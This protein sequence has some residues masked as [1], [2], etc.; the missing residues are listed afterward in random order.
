[1]PTIANP[2][3]WIGFLLFV[4]AMLALDLGVFHRKAHSVGFREAA[5]WSG[6]W[7]SLSMLFGAGLTWFSGAQAGEEFFTG[8]LIEKS[9][10][11]DNIFVF[12]L[13]FST[14]AIPAPSQHRVLFWGIL[15]ALILRA[16]MIFAGVALLTHFHWLIY[17]F[18]AFLLLT[19]VRLLRSWH[20]GIENS[21]EGTLQ[22]IRRFVPSTS[23]LHGERFFIREKGKRLATPLFVALVLVEVTDIIFAVDSIPAI[24]AV[25]TDPFIVFT[26][27]ILALMGLRS[28][29]FL[30]A[31]LVHKF[32]YL[33]P[34]LA[35]VLLFV[36][37]KMV[38][39]DWLPIPSVVSLIVIA[40][41]LA[42]G[43]IASLRRPMSADS[44]QL[45]K[46]SD[47]PA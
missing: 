43:V 23:Q 2:A 31:G 34:A 15:F 10:S 29:Y 33:K 39:A 5:I 13:V 14:L 19:G 12:F 1:M 41:M 4:I 45:L 37:T 36:G 6:V 38:L 44:R 17:V 30:V 7:V 11:V 25:T 20:K 40:L 42:A 46:P 28:L 32:R 9:L 35:G 22:F 26:S 27:N 8:Y 21:G 24:F 3:W 47:R 18:G 16:V